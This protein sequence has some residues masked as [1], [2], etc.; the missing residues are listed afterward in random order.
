MF[1][2]NRVRKNSL[3]ESSGTQPG[4]RWMTGRSTSILLGS[5]LPP[6]PLK[7]LD[8]DGALDRSEEA[9]FDP[10]QL[11]RTEPAP[12]PRRA[13]DPPDPLPGANVLRNTAMRAPLAVRTHRSEGGR[14]IAGLAAGAHRT[15]SR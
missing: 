7:R 5:G 15:V 9:D 13:D 10:S 4:H 8:E 12:V 2:R 14:I 6:G 11:G 3:G 1:A